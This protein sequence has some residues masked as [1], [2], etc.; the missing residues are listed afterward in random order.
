M[1][2]I[3]LKEVEYIAFNYARDYLAY[4][5]PIPEFSTRFQNKL[6]SCLA[7]PFQTFSKKYLYRGLVAKA[8]ILFYLM[9][10]NHPFRNGNKRIAVTTLLVFLYKNNKWLKV[11]N[12]E[13]YNFAVWVAQSPASLKKEVVMG[14]EKFLNN[15]NINVK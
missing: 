2:N 13:F 6:E 14:I 4:N 10:K 15:H 1:K 5:E 12:K 3:S 8:A 9:I 7:V 11:D